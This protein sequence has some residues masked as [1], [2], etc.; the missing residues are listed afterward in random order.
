VEMRRLG[1]RRAAGGRPG[2]SDQAD[3]AG[4]S[5]SQ[6]LPTTSTNTTTRP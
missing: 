5:R 2:A 6:R 3:V 4:P 1:A